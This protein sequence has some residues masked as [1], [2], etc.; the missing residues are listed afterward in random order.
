[1]DLSSPQQIN[2]YSYSSNNPTTFSDPSGLLE[3]CAD[4]ACNIRYPVGGSKPKP[5]PKPKPE[6]DSSTPAPSPVGSNT[7][8]I[9]D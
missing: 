7:P 3:Q 5:K 9:G 1:M 2:G 8:S 6:D 4:E